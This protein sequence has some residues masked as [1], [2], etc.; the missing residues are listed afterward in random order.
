VVSGASSV[1]KAI[2]AGKK[3]AQSIDRYL[4]GKL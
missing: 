4:A 2:E 1:I 3:A